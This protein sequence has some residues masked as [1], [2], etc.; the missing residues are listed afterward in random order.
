MDAR[1][2]YIIAQALYVA[3]REMKKVPEPFTEHSNI[4]DM[5]RLLTTRF[6]G[7]K[8]LF[9]SIEKHQKESAQ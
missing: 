2:F 5:E 4:A 9:E 7:Y 8:E 1:E 3:S 6:G